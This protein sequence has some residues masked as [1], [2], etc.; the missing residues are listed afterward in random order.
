MYI[1]I[2]PSSS[3]HMS[4]HCLVVDHDFG[5]EPQHNHEAS[6]FGGILGILADESDPV[7]V[8]RYSRP[9]R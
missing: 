6:C 3:I 8:D 4:I 9:D 1:F 5:N 2:S 7:F